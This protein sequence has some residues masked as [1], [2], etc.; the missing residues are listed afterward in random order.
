VSDPR[1]S[2]IDPVGDADAYHRERE[3]RFRVLREPIG[4]TRDQVV[5]AGELD[6]MHFVARVGDDVIGCVLLD[7][8][9]PPPS[10][11][12][13]LRQMAVDPARRGTGVGRALVHAIELDARA[14]GVPSIEMHARSSAIG[15]YERLG[16]R[17][18]GAPFTEIGIPHVT[19]TRTL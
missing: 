1:I 14:H 18:V 6:W 13:R 9:T 17:V 7:L 15:F 5:M 4:M 10:A 16:Y 12:G 3:L 11:P 2:M 19:M 8:A